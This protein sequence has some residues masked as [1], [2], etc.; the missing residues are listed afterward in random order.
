MQRPFTAKFAINH[1]KNLTIRHTNSNFTDKL[2]EEPKKKPHIRPAETAYGF[3][4]CKDYDRVLYCREYPANY[5]TSHS[6]ESRVHKKTNR[7]PK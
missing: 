4:P 1:T 6:N 7:K 5:P 3:D 2:M